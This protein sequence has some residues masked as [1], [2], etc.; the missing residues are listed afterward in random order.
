V[1]ER[2]SGVTQ[3]AGECERE[4]VSERERET[5]NRPNRAG[6]SPTAN[7]ARESAPKSV[8]QKKK[9]KEKREKKKLAGFWLDSGQISPGSGRVL[10]ELLF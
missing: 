7:S 5:V 10:P 6:E 1:S 8:H 3:T 9:K 2:S 4:T